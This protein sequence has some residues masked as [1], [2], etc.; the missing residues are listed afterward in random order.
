ME[1]SQKAESEEFDPAA[2]DYKKGNT[3]CLIVVDWQNDFIEGPMAH[4]GV[5]GARTDSE[6]LF[7]F[8]HQY[9]GGITTIL[10]TVDTHNPLLPYSM[11]YSRHF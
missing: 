7:K 11:S 5:E 8:I 1:L 10:S 9:M 4:L 6:R 2:D 3:V